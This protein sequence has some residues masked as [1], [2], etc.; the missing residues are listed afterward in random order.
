V[1]TPAGR[2]QEVHV[3]AKTAAIL[4]REND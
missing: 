4:K 2:L 1:I 3:D